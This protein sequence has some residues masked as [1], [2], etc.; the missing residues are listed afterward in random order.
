MRD[1]FNDAASS[2]MEY[3]GDL[4]RTWFVLLES[5]YLIISYMEYV[6]DL[7]STWFVLL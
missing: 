7:V 6:G 4:V 2:N 3:V 1:Q 5:R